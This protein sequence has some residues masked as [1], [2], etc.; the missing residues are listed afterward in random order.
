MQR[1]QVR[2]VAREQYNAGMQFG[3]K[4]IFQC[5]KDVRYI[6]DA[7]VCQNIQN[8]AKEISHMEMVLDILYTA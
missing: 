7:I 5:N 4:K 1:C 8:V 2:V 3:S 6:H